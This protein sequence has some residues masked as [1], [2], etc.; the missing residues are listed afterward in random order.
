MEKMYI[1]ILSINDQIF[2][3]NKKEIF[4]KWNEFDSTTKLLKMK[5]FL[6]FFHFLFFIVMKKNIFDILFYSVFY[7]SVKSFE[8]IS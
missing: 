3:S 8:L 4:D 7:L 5:N 2:F 6:S 1:A